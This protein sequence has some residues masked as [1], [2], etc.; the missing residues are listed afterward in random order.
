MI[1]EP[2]TNPAYPD[3]PMWTSRRG[4]HGFVITEDNKLYQASSR[5]LYT[6]E[7]HPVEGQMIDLGEHQSLQEAIEACTNWR[8]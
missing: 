3:M 6:T 2:K 8:P 5:R 7:P 4:D 1:F